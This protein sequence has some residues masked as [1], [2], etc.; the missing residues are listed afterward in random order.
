MTGARCPRCDESLESLAGAEGL[1]YACPSCGGRAIGI[2]VLRRLVGAE[3]VAVLVRR[4]RAARREGARCPFGP[5][6]AAAIDV[7]AAAVEV[8]VCASCASVW[9]DPGELAALEPAVPDGP[10]RAAARPEPDPL[11]R[12]VAEFQVELQRKRWQSERDASPPDDFWSI[13]PA[14]LGLPIALDEPLETRTPA[15][16][17]LVLACCTVFLA[18]ASDLE[19]A[20]QVYGFDPAAP[21]RE[22]GW[23]SVCSFFLHADWLHLAGNLYFLAVFGRRVEG[24]LGAWRLLALTLIATV[25]GD[26]AHAFAL[27]PEPGER[28]IGA[29]GGISGVLACFA[30][31]FPRGRIGLLGFGIRFAQA[32]LRLPAAVAFGIWVLLQLYGAW[33]QAAGLTQVSALAHLGGAAAGFALGLAWRKGPAGSAAAAASARP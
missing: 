25:A 2:P 12:A 8:D 24:A 20:V 3:V 27:A 5:H 22:Y 15:V 13:L 9:F 31:L 21:W 18:T 4:A 32:W 16:W 29:S 6:A 30:V 28:L 33:E 23:P 19:R 17:L 7:A 14:V 26:L 11:R 10:G 1:Q